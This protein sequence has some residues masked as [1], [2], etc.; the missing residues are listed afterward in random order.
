MRPSMRHPQHS[1][2]SSSRHVRCASRRGFSFVELM[3]VVLIMGILAAA[4]V[5]TFYDSL[6]VPSRRVGRPPREGRSRAGPQHR[7][8]HQRQ[9][10]DHIRGIELHGQPRQSSISIDPATLFRQPRQCS[11]QDDDRD[12]QFRR[13]RQLVSFDGYGKPSSGG[14]VVAPDRMRITSAWSARCQTVHVKVES[15]Q[16]PRPSR[17]S[18]RKLCKYDEFRMTNDE[19]PTRCASIVLRHSSFAIRHFTSRS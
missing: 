17:T 15:D 19:C 3:I 6:L 5:P 12:G 4:A 9:P 2:C 13:Q 16:F 14:T 1:R 10:I 11:V 7:P 18:S 8:P